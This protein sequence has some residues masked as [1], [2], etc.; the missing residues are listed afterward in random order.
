MPI[1]G[2]AS[3]ATFSA[4]YSISLCSSLLPQ[5]SLASCWAAVLSASG[6][7]SRRSSYMPHPTFSGT[8]AT[9]AAR[10]MS[11]AVT[12][13]I[14]LPDKARCP[15]PYRSRRPSC[16]WCR[17]AGTTSAFSSRKTGKTR[18][19]SGVVAVTHQII[20]QHFLKKHHSALER[21][22][23]CF[24]DEVCARGEIVAVGGFVFEVR[25][26][27]KTQ[28]L[29]EI[30][31]MQPLKGIG[32]SH[33]VESLHDEARF[34]A[35]RGKQTNL[36]SAKPQ[37]LG[38]SHAECLVDRQVLCYRSARLRFRDNARGGGPFQFEPANSTVSM[39]DG[40][41]VHLGLCTSQR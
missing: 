41:E 4:I 36:R 31:L 19:S 40:M 25:F 8:L 17:A 22:R 10:L 16:G 12:S 21:V 7:T 33:S 20:K 3:S 30:F 18:N 23:A 32:F 9:L 1:L 15:F 38:G 11:S 6:K 28:C 27:R 2:F 26:R 34:C 24:R 37:F 35:F 5:H 13:P 14:R 29:A 39:P